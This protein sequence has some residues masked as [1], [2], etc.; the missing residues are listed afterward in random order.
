[1]VYSDEAMVD[2]SLHLIQEYRKAA[3]LLVRLRSLGGYVDRTTGRIHSTFDDKQASGRLSSTYPNLQQLAR[4]RT[5]DGEAIRCRNALQASAGC[6]L[7]A[8]DIA[9]ADI[10]VLASAI[11]NFPRSSDEHLAWL[12]RQRRE[13][14]EGALAPYREWL[15]DCRNPAFVGEG[16]PDP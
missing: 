13:R 2:D 10:R 1:R 5:I 14:L 11:E 4:E 6:E 8:F 15:L 3:S 9:Q 7:V 12:R 16:E